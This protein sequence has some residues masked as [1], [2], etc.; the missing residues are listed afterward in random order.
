MKE[1]FYVY[2]LLAKDN[3]FYIGFSNNLKRRL[4]QH[5]RG[6]VAA[7]RNRRPL[8]LIHYEYFINKQDAEAREKFLK[9][10]Y[11]HQQLNSIL[12]KTLPLTK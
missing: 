5:A 3:R 12:K 9:S 11:G 1:K 4:Q 10:G 8:K 2:I 6:E 7:T